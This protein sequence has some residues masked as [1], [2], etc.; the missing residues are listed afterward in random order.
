MDLLNLFLNGLSASLQPSNLLF[1]LI[2][3]IIGT[4]VGVLP[5][6][7]PVAGIAILLPLTYGMTPEGALIMLAAIYYGTMYGGTITSVLMNVPGESASVV[8]AIDGYQMARQGRAGAALSVAAIGSFIGGTF[9]TL[10][11]IVLAAPLTRFAINFGPPEFFATVLVGFALLVTLAGESVVKGI[12]SSVFGLALTLPGLDPLTGVP[13][14]TFGF[15]DLLDGFGFIPILMG[16]FGISEILLNV[17]AKQQSLLTAPLSS[18]FLTRQD[19]RESAG[20][21]VRGSLLGFVIGV[22]PGLGAATASFIAYALEKRIARDPSR[23]GRGAIAGVA[24]PE[25]ANNASANAALLPLLTLGIPGSATVA[26]IMGA[27]LIH[28]I[29]PGPFLFQDHSQLVWTLIASMVVG[30][31]ILL[32]LNLPLVGLW[33]RILLLPY[34]LLFTVILVFT[35]IGTYSVNNSLFDVAVMLVFSVVGY[36]MRKLGFPLAPIALTL[37]L[38]PQFE[39]SLGQSLVLSDGNFNIFFRS[40]VSTGLIIVAVLAIALPMLGPVTHRLRR[41]RGQDSEV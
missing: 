35:I 6:V 22:I 14:L 1:A 41:M 3:S 2:G 12:I 5:G 33:A 11:I 30:N 26:L 13:R 9:S 23:F 15:P 4:L 29:T 25:T 20:P 16:L 10:G 31:V 27:F 34:P 28:G 8:T 32:V 36:V 40:Y 37:V 21:V 19:I 39:T 38:G 17:E 18:M 7:G 24:G